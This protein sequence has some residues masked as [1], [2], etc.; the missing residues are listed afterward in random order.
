MET[1]KRENLIQAYLVAYNQM[2]VAAMMEVLE[3]SVIFENYS[4]E[5]KTHEIRGKQAF[6]AQAKAAL[7]YFS[8]RKQSSISFDHRENET[9]VQIDYSAILAGDFPNGLKK[10]QELKLKGKSI[11]RFSNGK[12]KGIQDFS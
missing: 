9:E 11:F 6:E 3:D 12:I 10:G 2:D 8:E 7:S 4:E 5:K 1:I